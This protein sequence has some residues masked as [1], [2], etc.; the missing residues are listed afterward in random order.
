[1]RPARVIRLLEGATLVGAEGAVDGPAGG[2]QAAA[3]QPLALG[4]VRN[5][6]ALLVDGQVA[7]VAEQDHVA[8]LTLAVVADAAHGVLVNE[9]A[10]VGLAIRTDSKEVDGLWGGQNKKIKINQ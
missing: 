7:H 6:V 5:A 10:G 4:D 2:L 8:V 9:G 1:M 3:A